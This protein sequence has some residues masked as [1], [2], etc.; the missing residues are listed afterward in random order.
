MIDFS[1]NLYVENYNFQDTLDIRPATR[2]VIPTSEE[3]SGIEVRLSKVFIIDNKTRRFGPFPGLA[4][5]YFMNIVLSDLSTSEI[6]LN[7]NGFE[8]VDDRQTLAV[9]RTLF[10]W[11]KTDETLKPPS[12]IHIMSSLLK[13]KKG[14]RDTAG[15]IAKAKDDSNFKTLASSLTTVLKT[16]SNFSSISNIV[17]QVAGIVGGLLENVEDKPLLTR[18]QSFT[19]IAGDFNQLGKT[20]N[21]FSNRYAELDY[22]IFIRDN[23]RQKEADENKPA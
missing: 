19:D 1:Q 21:P 10:F 13:S 14:L 9:D 23:E 2:G 8:K 5:V 15:V 3:I 4:T 7:L 11:K 12:Q 18:F 16:A 17:F 22:S 20:D 6:D